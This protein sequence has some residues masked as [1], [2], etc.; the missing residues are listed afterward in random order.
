VSVNIIESH[1][2]YTSS[3]C[4]SV[5]YT[6]R[7]YRSFN[8]EKSR[9][10]LSGPR[11]LREEKRQRSQ[12]IENVRGLVLQDPSVKFLRKK[13][14]KTDKDFK[15]LSDFYSH[16]SEPCAK[17]ARQRGIENDLELLNIK[18][19]E[20]TSKILKRL[21]SKTRSKNSHNARWS[22]TD[23]S[24]GKHRKANQVKDIAPNA[25]KNSHNL[26]RE[27]CKDFDL[28]K[29]FVVNPMVTNKFKPIDRQCSSKPQRDRWSVTLSKTSR[30]K[31]D[32][33]DQPLNPINRSATPPTLIGLLARVHSRGKVSVE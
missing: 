5:W 10:L 31:V 27:L 6:E 4:L 11:S 23:H 24:G 20:S 8:L 15:W 2:E 13:Q 30:K 17:A 7:E 16:H 26:R 1:N 9:E 29:K 19:I 12:R 25:I 14:N 28:S 18:L 32:K 22:E 33:G 21:L 3:E